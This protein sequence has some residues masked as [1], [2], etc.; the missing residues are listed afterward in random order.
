MKE[1]D[2]RKSQCSLNLGNLVKS[3]FR[4]RGYDLKNSKFFKKTCFVK[5]ILHGEVFWL[6]YLCSSLHRLNLKQ[7]MFIN[8]QDANCFGRVK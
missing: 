8:T 6:L 2:V 7:I 3:E 1:S 5:W 4:F